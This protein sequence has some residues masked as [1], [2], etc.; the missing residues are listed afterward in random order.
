MFHTLDEVLKQHDCPH[1]GKGIHVYTFLGAG[2]KLTFAAE[3]CNS[4][5]HRTGRGSSIQEALEDLQD[6]C[7]DL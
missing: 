1:T 2:E 6:K 5:V 3:F 4:A 7:K